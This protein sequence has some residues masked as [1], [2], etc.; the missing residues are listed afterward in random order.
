M[1]KFI[2]Y[3]LSLGLATSTFA[4]DEEL[5]KQAKLYFKPLPKE[6]P[7]PAYNPTTPEKIQLGKKLYF[8]PRLSLSGVISC[9]TCHN[10]STYGVDGVE[11][12]LGHKFLTGGRNAPTVLNA[13]F[14]FAQ[15]W[16]GRAKDL[17][18]Q[19]K[20]PILASVEMA[21]PNP[22]L[23]IS[24]LKTIKEY[25]EEFKKAF[26]ND[27]QPV[28]YEN[29]AKAIAAFERTLVTPSRFDEFLR[30]NTDALT[31]KEKEGL[32]LFM[33]KGCASC[34]QGVALG[35]TMYQK[36]GLVKPYP[37]ELIGED[38]GRYN[39]TKKEEDKYVFKVPIL[40]N[41]TRT[42]PYFSKG[43]IWDIKEAVKIMGEYQLGINLTDEEVDK[44]VAFLDSL[45]G[46]IP[47]E[48]L[49]LPVLPPSAPNTPKPQL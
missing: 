18:E 34:H 4:S 11:T 21:M 44:I 41:I 49:Q 6:I 36:M 28:N 12:S 47:K 37:K 31:K 43:K 5:L 8:D 1:K 27:K 20:G 32:K 2:S 24:R 16:D 9:N 46:K 23:V 10:L 13:G 38:L 33:E 40:R 14:Q 30:G 19:A 42:Y 35:G 22:E 45:T 15:F 29:V 7:A 26:P 39:I 3:V 48:A 17:E 25:V